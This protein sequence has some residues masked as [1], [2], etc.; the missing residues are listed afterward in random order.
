LGTWDYTLYTESEGSTYGYDSGTI[1]FEGTDSAGTYAQI[2]FYE[3]K[4][5]GE[6]V[7]NGEAVTLTGDQTWT[8]EFT[9]ATHMSGTWE[10]PDDDVAGTWT[11]TKQ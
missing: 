4:Y 6:Y 7:V 9:D 2:D 8:G 11:A 1:T 5:G 3:V 10:A